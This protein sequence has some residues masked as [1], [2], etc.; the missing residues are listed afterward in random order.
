MIRLGRA[1]AP[2]LAVLP[3]ALVSTLLG[4]PLLAAHPTKVIAEPTPG[5]SG[6]GDPYWPLDGN[7][8]I[9]VLRYDVHDRYRFTTGRLSGWTTLKI[10]ATQDLPRF[11]LDFLLP[12]TGVL[13]DGA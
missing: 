6:I 2:L 12:V 9:N 7:G 3:A 10:R 4:S 13:V 8:G 11:N 5:S 1:R